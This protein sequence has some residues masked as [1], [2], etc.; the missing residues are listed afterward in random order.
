LRSFVRRGG[1]R[2]TPVS[3]DKLSRIPVRG[4]ASMVPLNMD[5]MVGKIQPFREKTCEPQFLQTGKR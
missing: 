5:D 1:L 4:A 2:I 3:R